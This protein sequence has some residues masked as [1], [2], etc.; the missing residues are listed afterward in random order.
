M[1]WWEKGF[2]EKEDESLILW[3][4]HLKIEDVELHFF[5]SSVKLFSRCRSN[6]VDSLKGFSVDIQ[7]SIKADALEVLLDKG[8]GYVW[9]IEFVAVG[10][11]EH[12]GFSV[13]P[14]YPAAFAVELWLEEIAFA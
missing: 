2:I 7:F 9:E 10:R 13:E 11:D 8:S 14:L 5:H 6:G 4:R 3:S 12:R 1:E